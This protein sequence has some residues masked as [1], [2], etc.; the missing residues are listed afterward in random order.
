M[1]PSGSCCQSIDTRIKRGR[2]GVFLRFGF[3]SNIPFTAAPTRGVLALLVGGLACRLGQRC[4]APT[5]LSGRRR[6]PAG[7]QNGCNSSSINFSMQFTSGCMGVNLIPRRIVGMRREYPPFWL[8]LLI[9]SCRLTQNQNETIS[10]C[11]LPAGKG[12]E[13]SKKAAGFSP[14]AC[15]DSDSV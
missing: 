6:R 7:K 2:T 12:L 9:L 10:F 13:G 5:A 4:R 14:A 3:F 1:P 11:F 8:I 15:R